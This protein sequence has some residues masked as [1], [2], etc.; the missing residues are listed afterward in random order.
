MDDFHLYQRISETIRREILTGRLKP[1]QRLPSMR[2]LSLQWN[3]TPGTVQKSYNLLAKE[4][5]VISQAG[6]GTQV[7]GSTPKAMFQTQESLQMAHLVN[8]SETFLL[9]ALTAGYALDEIQLALEMAMDRWR[10]PDPL[11][12]RPPTNVLR[13]AGS[14]DMALAGLARHVFGGLIADT[15]LQ[16][17]FIGSLGGLLAMAQ[18][19]ADLCGCHLWDGQ[20][21][22]YNL[23]FIRQ[24]FQGEEVIVVTL[25]QRRLG[26]IV[27]PGNPLG[28]QGIADLK[29]AELRFV[30]RQAGSGTRHW[31]DGEL[32]KAEIEPRL[33]NGYR[34]ER[35]THSDVARAVAEGQADVGLGLE[36][37]A[38]AYKQDFIYL[39]QERYDLVLDAEKAQGQA[40]QQFIAWLQSQAAKEFIARYIGYDTRLTGEIQ[41]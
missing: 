14:H 29:R 40:M 32:E 8:R 15:H 41:T 7:A 35:L 27:A 37:A 31:L 38:A 34:D 22:T 36:S 28:I 17:T 24:H 23:S 10:A 5:L 4:G 30:N 39:T 11:V 16:L 20:S 2:Q 12:E 1:G 9:E 26:L 21:K 13:F 6:R 3:C 33:V 19:K 25:A 18:G